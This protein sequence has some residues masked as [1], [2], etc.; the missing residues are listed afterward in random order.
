METKM[1]GNARTPTTIMVRSGNQ[2]GASS[3]GEGDKAAGMK[4]RKAVPHRALPDAPITE[5][6][7]C[8][9]L[10][11][12]LR[13]QRLPTKAAVQKLARRLESERKA[14][15]WHY[16]VWVPQV[17]REVAACR[18]A[19]TLFVELPRLAVELQERLDNPGALTQ[20]LMNS[21]PSVRQEYTRRLAIISPLTK[22][23]WVDSLSS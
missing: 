22:S 9:V 3:R 8:E 13:R 1:S 10:R 18:A 23:A 2:P 14:V 19:G 12:V 21:N 15:H 17:A 5:D 11:T 7:V 16:E 6:R 4:R 20:Y